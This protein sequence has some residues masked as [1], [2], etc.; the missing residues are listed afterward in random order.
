MPL[1]PLSS[2][3]SNVENVEA[4]SDHLRKA[5]GELALLR[6][7]LPEDGKER[8]RVETM[9][10]DIGDVLSRAASLSSRL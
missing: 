10:A 5:A 3:R 4:A 6:D 8:P 2:G 7:R 1:S 9:I